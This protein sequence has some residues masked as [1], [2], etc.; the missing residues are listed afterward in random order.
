MKQRIVSRGDPRDGQK[1]D[2]WDEY[3]E[4]VL[5]EERRPFPHYYLKTDGESFEEECDAIVKECL[6][7][8]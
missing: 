3:V 5:T 8:R 4:N 2:K 7:D 1:L 6:R